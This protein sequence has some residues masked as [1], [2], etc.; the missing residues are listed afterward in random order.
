MQIT[1]RSTKPQ[2]LEA[3]QELEQQVK[4][5]QEQLIGATILSG[6]ITTLLLVALF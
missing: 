6:F 5:S 2:I 3:Y 4:T 1:Q